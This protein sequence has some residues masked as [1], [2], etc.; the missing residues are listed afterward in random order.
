MFAVLTGGVNPN[1]RPLGAATCSITNATESGL[2]VT[3]TTTGSA[4]ILPGQLV[5][6]TRNPS[7]VR[8]RGHTATV[9]SLMP[10]LAIPD[11]T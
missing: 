3:I 10:I 2:V 9:S 1:N 11:A 7:I 6:I 8:S 5:T 4:A